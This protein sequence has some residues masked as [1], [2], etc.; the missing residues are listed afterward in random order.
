MGLRWCPGLGALQRDGN[1]LIRLLL[2]PLCLSQPPESGKTRRSIRH[3]DST[4]HRPKGADS[5][6]SAPPSPG[7]S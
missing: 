2:R 5:P 3:L 6:G 1:P 7:R 4:Q